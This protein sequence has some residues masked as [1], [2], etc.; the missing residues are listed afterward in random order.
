M[1][2]SRMFTKLAEYQEGGFAHGIDYSK[3]QLPKKNPCALV[4]RPRPKK[5]SQIAT[6]QEFDRLRYLADDDMT[7]ILNMLFFTRLRPSDLKRLTSNEIDLNH[8]KIDLIQH[9]TITT[10]NPSGIQLIIP[11][12]QRI[13]DILLPRMAR[14]KPGTPLFPW[15]NIQKRWQDLREKVGC[16]HLQLGRDFRRTA[17]TFLTDNGVDDLTNA[18]GL[19]HADT[20]MLPTYAPRTITNQK[21]SLE[22]LENSWK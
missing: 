4:P 7:D 5:R 14:C 12:S 19:G 2:L 9:K 8:M 16:S 13:A 20:T 10:K 11:I 22:I 6:Q 1:L 21:K 18:Q 15:K 3:I 17:A